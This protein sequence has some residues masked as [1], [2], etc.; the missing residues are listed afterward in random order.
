MQRAFVYRISQGLVTAL[1]MFI[2]SQAAL[3]E[4]RTIHTLYGEVTVEGQPERV[5]TLYDG[6]LTGQIC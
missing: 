2:A 4:T 3:A 6:I 1:A 5:V